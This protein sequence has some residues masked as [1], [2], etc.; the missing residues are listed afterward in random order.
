MISKYEV[1]TVFVIVV[2]YIIYEGWGNREEWFEQGQEAEATAA[3]YKN[4]W[5]GV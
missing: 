2:G 3:R 5:R 1:Q 4:A